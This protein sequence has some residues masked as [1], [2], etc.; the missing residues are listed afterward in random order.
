MQRAHEQA[1]ELVK[2]DRALADAVKLAEK[3]RLEAEASEAGKAKTVIAKSNLKRRFDDSELLD[4][5]NLSL[6]KRERRIG[7]RLR[8]S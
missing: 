6:K 4:E 2:K 7:R 8:G 3:Y 5:K 1:Q